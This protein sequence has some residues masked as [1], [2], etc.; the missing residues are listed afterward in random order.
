MK[1]ELFLCKYNDNELISD[2]SLSMLVELLS[3][4]NM[5][6]VMHYVKT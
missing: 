4:I 3:S 5:R 6:V 2:S 1:F